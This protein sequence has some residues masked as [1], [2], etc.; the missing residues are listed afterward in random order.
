MAAQCLHE[1]ETRAV[2]LR[3]QDAKKQGPRPRKKSSFFTKVTEYF[4]AN[5]H[6]T[7]TLAEAL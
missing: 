7:S 2:L 5:F 1:A 4:S 3:K 6:L